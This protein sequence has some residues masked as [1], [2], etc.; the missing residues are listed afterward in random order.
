MTLFRVFRG[1]LS[2]AAARISETALFPLFRL[3]VSETADVLPPPAVPA[4]SALT[5]NFYG[6]CLDTGEE[7]RFRDDG[8][9]FNG[10]QLFYPQNIRRPTVKDKVSGRKT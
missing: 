7:K 8:G 2:Y 6:D 3:P 4:S 9:N 5:E 10:L 1:I